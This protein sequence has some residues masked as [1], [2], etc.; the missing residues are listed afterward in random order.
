MIQVK[1]MNIRAFMLVAALFMV[2]ILSIPALAEPNIPYD[3]GR[4]SINTEVSGEAAVNE[5]VSLIWS[6]G[7][8]GAMNTYEWKQSDTFANPGD[9]TSHTRFTMEI[10][11]ESTSWDYLRWNTGNQPVI[12]GSWFM[13]E[14][15]IMQPQYL[16][17]GPVRFSPPV[18]YS[19]L[20]SYLPYL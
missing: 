1:T 20:G 3:F 8:G 2:T 18:P 11:N 15:T 10:G 7:T 16:T 12:P 14:N 9:Y 4:M 13:N 5:T 19:P 6:T 17:S